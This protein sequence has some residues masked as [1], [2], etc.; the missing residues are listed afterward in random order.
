MATPAQTLFAGMDR[1]FME[2]WRDVRVLAY[3][4]E[5]DYPRLRAHFVLAWEARESWVESPGEI[6]WLKAYSELQSQ[7]AERQ[8]QRREEFQHALALL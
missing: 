1:A 5:P 2:Y 6:D 4:E 3:G 7:E 8:R